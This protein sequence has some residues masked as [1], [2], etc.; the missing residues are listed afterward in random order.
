MVR[1]TL[2]ATT[3]LV[4]GASLAFAAQHNDK[5]FSKLP[6]RF[7]PA[8]QHASLVI[9]KSANHGVVHNN[10]SHW[11][12]GS[13]FSNFSKDANAEFVSW[14]G[15]TALNS[16]YSYYSTST[17]H[18]KVTDKS[19]NATPFTGSGKLKTMTFAGF[20]YSANDE[21]QGQILSATSSGLPGAALATTSATTFSDTADCCTS[22]RTV[23]FTSGAKSLPS[24]NYFASVECANSPCYG[25]WAMENVDF[26]GAAVDYYHYYE[27]ETYNYGSGTHTSVY[28]SPWHES[29][30]FPTNGAVIV[31]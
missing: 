30:E 11:T 16:S 13:V 7:Q 19:N 1:K 22:A 9:N 8:N 17:Y 31:K 26:T 27:K 4:L 28:S 10:K 12:P 23:K 25:G 15:Y 21:F 24:G 3:A 6:A 18:Y 20:A 29:T 2:L 5:A 14:Y